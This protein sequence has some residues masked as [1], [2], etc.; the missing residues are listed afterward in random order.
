MVYYTDS[1]GFGGAETVLLTLMEGLD[2]RVWRPILIHH[3]HP[4]VAVLAR[5]AH[6]LGV[7]TREFG[8]V[9]GH[10]D[11]GWLLRFRKA[12]RR[13][14][15]SIFHAHLVW[16]L[17]CTYGL[18]AARLARI[19]V[20]ATQHAFT[21]IG[22]GH[23][24]RLQKAVSLAVDRYIAVSEQLGRDLTPFIISKRKVRVIYSAIRSQSFVRPPDPTLRVSLTGGRARPLVLTVA[25]LDKLKGLSHLIEAAV[26][27]PQAVFVVAG[28]GSERADLEARARA[29]GVAD[30]IV[31]LGHRDDIPEL[32]AASDIFVLPSLC[33][34]LGL[35]VLEAMASGKPVVA[36]RIGGI[37]E[38]VEDG[39]SGLLVAPHDAGALA[40]AIRA[41]LQDKSL[42]N[43]LAAAGRARVVERFGA[44]TMVQKTMDLYEELTA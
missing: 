8:T 23:E 32:L 5:R 12:L 18:V 26:Q 35:S 9:P 28:E 22:T 6:D 27:V 42:A 10:R 39:V 38:A 33:E 29:S 13:E 3:A 4:G 2:R 15:T 1:E 17:A 36:T 7:S 25:R 30:R 14:G 21:K 40:S 19:P 11:I 16:P 34:G 20:V 31:F 24:V 44:E 41:L 43:R 37:P